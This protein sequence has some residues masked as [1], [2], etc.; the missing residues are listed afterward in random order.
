ME[1]VERLVPWVIGGVLALFILFI[2]FRLTGIEAVECVNNH[3]RGAE[4]YPGPPAMQVS[5]HT[6]RTDAS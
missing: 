6:D 5:V 2:A 4:L 3:R 1:R